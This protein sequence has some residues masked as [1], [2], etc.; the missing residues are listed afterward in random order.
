[1]VAQAGEGQ[2][3]HPGLSRRT[4][5]KTLIL[6]SL[7]SLGKDSHVTAD[8]ILDNLK[9]TALR[10]QNPPYTA[11]SHSWKRAGSCESIFFRR[12]PRPVTSS[13]ERIPPARNTITSYAKSA[14]TSSTSK[15]KTCRKFSKGSGNGRA[16]AST[17][18]EVS[19]TVSAATARRKRRI[20]R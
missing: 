9:K 4:R 7:E 15:A 2:E 3:K 10:W 6:S 12:V 20:N 14:A 8:E 19:F 17:G 13:S 11:S 18:Q 5:Q 16:S 1:M